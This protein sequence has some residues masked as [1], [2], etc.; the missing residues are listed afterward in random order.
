MDD[1]V[2][3]PESCLEVLALPAGCCEPSTGSGSATSAPSP[4]SAVSL[5]ERRILRVHPSLA[6]DPQDN[7]AS[8]YSWLL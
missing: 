2:P 7:D 8:A 4:S 6:A 1:A 3:L 5:S